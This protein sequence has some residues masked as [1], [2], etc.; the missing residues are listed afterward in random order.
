MGQL[1]PAEQ[2]ATQAFTDQ[3]KL[4]WDA[5]LRGQ[6]SC[7]WR[8]AILFSSPVR[9]NDTTETHMRRL[10]KEFHS[11]SLSVWNFQNGGLHGDTYNSRQAVRR[12]LIR[13]KVK[14]GFSLYEAG[15]MLLLPWDTNLFTKYTLEPRLQRDDDA[16]LCWLRS[17]KVAMNVYDK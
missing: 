13:E 16:L 17:V 11:F 1:M 3:T 2:M 9:D 5:F 6:L 8:Q 15:K 10:L 12:A 14:D 7:S 4:G